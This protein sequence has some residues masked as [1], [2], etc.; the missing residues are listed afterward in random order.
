MLKICSTLPLK[1]QHLWPFT[2]KG[3]LCISPWTVQ[4]ISRSQGVNLRF[5]AVNSKSHAVFTPV[6]KF[7]TPTVKSNHAMKYK[8]EWSIFHAVKLM[9][10]KWKPCHESFRWWGVSKT[11][12]RGRGLLF[13]LCY[14]NT[15]LQFMWSFCHGTLKHFLLRCWLLE[16]LKKRMEN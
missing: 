11:L 2:R 6:R 10:V 16:I 15:T 5:H 12:T 8:K 13:V 1:Q 7:F 4:F 3:G 9:R 14:T